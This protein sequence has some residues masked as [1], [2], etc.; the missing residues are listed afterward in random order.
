MRPVSALHDPFTDHDG[1]RWITPSIFQKQNGSVVDE[2]T[3]GEMVSDAPSI[4]KKHWDTWATLADFQ[5]I[6]KHGF[7]TVRIPIGCK[8]RFVERPAGF[9]L[10]IIIQT[11]P[12]R[13]SMTHMSKA[14]H[15]IWIR[16][17]RGLG[18]LGSKFTSISMEPLDPRMASIIPVNAS[19]N[20]GN[21]SGQPETPWIRH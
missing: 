17:L 5:K 1:T 14:Q 20:Q 9:K 12:T 21:P 19:R 18:K 7:N 2:Y 8:F 3:L 13:S 6:A 4:L 10:M 11:G 15:H 16:P